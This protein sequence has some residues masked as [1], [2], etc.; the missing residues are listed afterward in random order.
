MRCLIAAFALLACAIVHADIIHLKNGKTLHGEVIREDG[1]FVTIKVPYGEVKLKKS[2]IEAIERQ[3]PLEYKLDVGR[4]MLSQRNYTRAV[5]VF[6]DAY[7]ANR[8]N[9]DAKRILCSAYEL[10]GKNCRELHRFREAREAF[11]KLQKLDPD[12]DEIPH[13]AGALLKDIVSEEQ[14]ADLIF[15]KAN[16]LAAAQEWS[17]AIVAFEELIAYTP[18]ARAK[19]GPPMARCHVHRAVELA[20]ASKVDEAVQDLET[21]LGLDPTLADSVENFYTSC[22]LPG[23]LN[24]LARGELTEA[25]ASLKRVLSFAPSNANVLYAAGRLEEANGKLASAADLYARALKIRAPGSGKEAIKTLRQSLEKELKIQGDRLVIDTDFA[26]L[27]EFSKASDGPAQKIESEHF[28]VFHHNESLA[29]QVAEAAEYHRTRI[30]AELGVQNSWR[31]KA[32]IFLHRTQQEYTASTGQPEWTGGA[33]KFSF[34]GNQLHDPQVHS[35]QTSPRLL[36]S[37]LPHEIAHLVVNANVSDA[38]GLPKCL[39]EGFAVLMEPRFRQDYFLNFLR[40][41]VKSQDFIS[42][43]DLLSAKDYPRDPEFFY[44]EGF[45]I[46]QYLAREQGVTAVVPLLKVSAAN[47]VPG[48]LLK[49]SGCKSIEELEAGWK[50]WILSNVGK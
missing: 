32:K 34:I 16:Q 1:D 14:D 22:A 12:G 26:Q 46:L 48:E 2:D 50:K 20:R 5:S 19:A 18:D 7:F 44:A 49:V 28:V 27:Q 31:G 35:W 47:Q 29:R 21:A 15:N 8:E 43:T 9:M 23:I 39:H 33:S 45:S 37:V 10:L 30:G 38:N 36:K 24:N 42:L 3:T 17:K 11:E 4:Q 40:V 41:R 6:E 13:K 25:Q